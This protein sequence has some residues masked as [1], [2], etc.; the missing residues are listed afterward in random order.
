ME[1][2]ELPFKA[3]SLI[4]VTDMIDKDW[5]WGQFGGKEGW[6]PSTFVRVSNSNPI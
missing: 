2:D 3:G 4:N 1:V 5:W 6:F